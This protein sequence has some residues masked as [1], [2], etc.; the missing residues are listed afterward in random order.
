M[1]CFFGL[2]DCGTKSSSSIDVINASAISVSTNVL[3]SCS[4]TASLNQTQNNVFSGDATITGSTFSNSSGAVVNFSCALS[5]NASNDISNAVAAQ[6][7]QMA[8]T[9][10]YDLTGILSC[11]QSEV[12][13]KLSSVL[14]TSVN[15]S[16]TQQQSNAISVNQTQNNVFM[17][18]ANISDAIF[19]QKSSLNIVASNVAKSITNNAVVQQIAA[20]IDQKSDTETKSTIVG[21]IDSVGGVISKIISTPLYL[22]M[23]L[24]VIVVVIALVI[25]AWAKNNTDVANTPS[26]ANHTN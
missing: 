6:I 18:N 8:S 21:A 19:E 20:G 11:T 14:S 3:Q 9:K 2:G 17:G 5:N 16:L 12:N 23:M 1:V 22:I 25:R 26:A 7:Q 10:G 13:A 15:S 4:N 24:F